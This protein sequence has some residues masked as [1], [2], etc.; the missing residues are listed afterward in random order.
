MRAGWW[1]SVVLGL[2]LGTAVE[3][4]Q[5]DPTILSRPGTV[6]AEGVTGPRDQGQAPD[7]H[8]ADSR[9]RRRR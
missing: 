8:G 4:A 2:T 5:Q 6:P 7:R 1:G 3:A 9:A